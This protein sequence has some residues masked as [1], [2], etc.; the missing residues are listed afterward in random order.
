[1]VERRGIRWVNVRQRLL[2]VQPGCTVSFRSP[3]GRRNRELDTY[4]D[5]RNVQQL[6]SGALISHQSR[7]IAIRS[8]YPRPFVAFLHYVHAGGIRPR[9]DKVLSEVSLHR[10]SASCL[11]SASI[12]CAYLALSETSS[13]ARHEPLP[14][15]CN[16]GDAT[17]FPQ[18]TCL[19][20]KYIDPEVEY[21]DTA[22]LQ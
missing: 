11:F 7:V 6:R 14:S 20:G 21:A 9:L 17:Q 13:Q 2:S 8:I 1:M 16:L 3:V 22:R 4:L 18:E 12:E 5:P 10:R 15:L 19:S